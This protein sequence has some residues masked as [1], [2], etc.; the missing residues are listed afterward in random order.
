MIEKIVN[1]NRFVLYDDIKETPNWRFVEFNK[2]VLIDANIGSDIV[3]VASR[4]DLVM[5]LIEAEQYEKAHQEAK[6]YKQSIAFT[7]NNIDIKM[8][9]FI[10][11]CKSINGKEITSLNESD[12]KKWSE[13]IN[14]TNVS[15]NFIERI[16]SLF[17]KKV[18][19]DLT[20]YFPHHKR[21][22]KVF[23][24]LKDTLLL[25][26]QNM[27]EKSEIKEKSIAHNKKTILEEYKPINFFG[28]AGFEVTTDKKYIE[29]CKILG[30]GPKELTIFEF[31][32]I[33][34]KFIKDNTE[35]VRN[36]R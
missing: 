25:R 22:N 18:E 1:G 30:V 29:T 23:R 16:V 28:S 5:Q 3:D 7:V 11:A 6:N 24:L 35:N 33:L 34:S 26:L 17:K 2:Y 31:Q 32:T 10:C 14:K 9:C 36:K 8:F 27:R 12:L 4:A 13:E 19:E 20:L 21:N 15:R